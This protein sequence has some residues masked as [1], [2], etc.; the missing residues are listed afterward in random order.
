MTTF[1]AKEDVK[2]QDSFKAAVTSAN[3]IIIP[4]PVPIPVPVPR[5]PWR[6]RW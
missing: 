6:R 3:I 4:I 5:R 1:S 2:L